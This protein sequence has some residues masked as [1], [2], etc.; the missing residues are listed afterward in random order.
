MNE[1]KKTVGPGK[2]KLEGAIFVT[3]PAAIKGKENPVLESP[4]IAGTDHNPSHPRRVK[5]TFVFTVTVFLGG[6]GGVNK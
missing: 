4:V 2:K 6:G 3:F 5:S 1:Y